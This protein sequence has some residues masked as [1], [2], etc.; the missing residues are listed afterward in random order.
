MP[1]VSASFEWK[2]GGPDRLKKK[3]RKLEQVF[4]DE[5]LPKA[6]GDIA[7]HI[8]REAKQRAPVESGNLRASIASVVE[9]IANGY[10][11]VV[12]TNV[13]YAREVEFGTGPHTITGDP[14][15]FTVD[16]EVVFATEVNHPGTP[17]QPF[18]GPALRTS[19]DYIERRLKEA[20]QTAV[21]RV[22]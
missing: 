16:G 6:M 2:S 17:A 21:G 10:R 4:L 13:E 19:E 15:R 3:L 7:L 8:E 20:F 14:L 1:T 11:A 18:L 22:S 5:E 12:G 9:T